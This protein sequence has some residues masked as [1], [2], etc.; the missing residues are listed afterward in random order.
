MNHECQ[1][2]NKFTGLDASSCLFRPEHKQGKTF[3]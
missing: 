1:M 3:D 2:A